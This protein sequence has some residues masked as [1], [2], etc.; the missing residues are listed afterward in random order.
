M[1]HTDPEKQRLQELNSDVNHHSGSRL[2]PKSY[3][4]R[5]NPNRI[6]KALKLSWLST[7]GETKLGV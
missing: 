4:H 2:T 6:A 7:E 1:C 5:A 3:T